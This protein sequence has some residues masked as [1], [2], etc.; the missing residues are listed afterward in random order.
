MTSRDTVNQQ[1]LVRQLSFIR[2]S[3]PS[4]KLEVVM[5]GQGLDIVI[6]DLSGQRAAVE[7]LLADK[8]ISFK[9]CAVTMERQKVDKAQLL[10]G[11]EVVPDGIYEIITK[12]QQGWG[13]IKVAH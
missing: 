6:R 7:K 8:N 9:V 11:V 2:E 5:Y 4:S 10:A 1:A 12:Q 13:Y 3:N